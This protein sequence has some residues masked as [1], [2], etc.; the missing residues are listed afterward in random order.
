M[1]ATP[2]QPGHAAA[3]CGTGKILGDGVCLWGGGWGGMGDSG[4]QCVNPNMSYHQSD[5]VG[6]RLWH[7]IIHEAVA[8]PPHTKQASIL[9]WRQTSGRRGGEGGTDSQTQNSGE[10]VSA[11][12]MNFRISSVELDILNHP[13]LGR[14]RGWGNARWDAHGRAA[15]AR[16]TERAV[17]SDRA[18]V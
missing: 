14:R 12:E 6:I 11:S 5:S 7:I 16:T 17:A 13:C 15:G 9:R 8:A 3:T 18:K 10:M 4:S 1:P 2:R